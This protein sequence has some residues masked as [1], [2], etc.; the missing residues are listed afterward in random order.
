M[1]AVGG[2]SV[3]LTS[4]LIG[5]I[6]VAHVLLSLQRVG[7]DQSL[8]VGEFLHTLFSEFVKTAVLA[9]GL[10]GAAY[11]HSLLVVGIQRMASQMVVQLSHRP[12]D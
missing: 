12:W 1:L 8:M 11:H 10:G 5:P 4:E 6:L 9:I 3:D 7:L 2:G